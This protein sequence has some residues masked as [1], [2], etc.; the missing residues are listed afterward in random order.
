MDL[1]RR[2]SG[3][4]VPRDPDRVHIRED[5]V[6]TKTFTLL[7]GETHLI[8]TRFT[9]ESFFMDLTEEEKKRL[10]FSGRSR[11][12]QV[13]GVPSRLAAETVITSLEIEQDEGN[14]GEFICG[15]PFENMSA[16]SLELKAGDRIA[17]AYL[18]PDLPIMNGDLEDL[19]N[20]HYIQMDG[21]P[22]SG[23]KGTKNYGFWDYFYEKDENGV[24]R[25]AGIQFRI[26][27]GEEDRAFI[28]KD[29]GTIHMPTSVPNFREVAKSYWK[30][31]KYRPNK[32]APGLWFGKTI[33]TNFDYPI[34]AEID[35]KAY[36]HIDRNQPHGHGWE[37]IESRLL[38][39]DDNWNII[40]ELY[41]PTEGD[42]VPEWIIFRFYRQA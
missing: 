4:I 37:H 41:S 17:R 22:G 3:L 36:P 40:A 28:P 16:A 21:K 10:R 12:A 35:P 14:N 32:S 38:G 8:R 9:P 39:S 27:D 5:A 6:V 33:P 23:K 19:V 29:A 15:M 2:P 24:E 31:I 11:L 34:V 18:V 26:L 13:G 1:E 42:H 30:D 25:K 20:S 7:P